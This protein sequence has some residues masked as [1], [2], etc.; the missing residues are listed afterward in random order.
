MLGDPQ[1]YKRVYKIE[2]GL[3]CFHVYF[4]FFRKPQEWDLTG[5]NLYNEIQILCMWLGLYCQRKGSSDVNIRIVKLKEIISVAYKQ[6]S[7]FDRGDL[8]LIQGTTLG[9]YD[10]QSGTYTCLFPNTLVFPF[11]N[12]PPIFYIHPCIYVWCCIIT[13]RTSLNRTKIVE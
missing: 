7:A 13:L 6:S 5:L 12:I 9:I 2:N 11:S 3:K 8:G 4:F 1:G 10:G